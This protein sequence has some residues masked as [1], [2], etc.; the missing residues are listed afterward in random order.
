[1]EELGRVEKNEMN[2]KNVAIVR[3]YQASWIRE[4]QQVRAVQQP[5]TNVTSAASND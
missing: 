3:D 2:A 4:H 5:A 1:M